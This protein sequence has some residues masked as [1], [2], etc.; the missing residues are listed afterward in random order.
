M[1]V[2]GFHDGTIAPQRDDPLLPLSAVCASRR[3]PDTNGRGQYLTDVA[4][5][6]SASDEEQLALD[7]CRYS[8][9]IL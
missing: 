6:A 1:K 2:S 4:G 5:A 7:R 3:L 8:S 9:R